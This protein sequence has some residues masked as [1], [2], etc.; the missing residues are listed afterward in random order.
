[1]KKIGRGKIFLGIIVSFIILTLGSILY[2]ENILQHGSEVFLETRP[3]DP[4]D[5]LRG[6]YITLA[7][8]IEN[9]QKVIN[10]ISNNKL[11][12]DDTI[13]I[14]LDNSDKYAKVKKVSLEKPNDKIY[15][16]GVVD[17]RGV[18][19]PQINKF[20]VPED[21]GL[22]LERNSGKM[23]VQVSILNDNA[24]IKK[25]FIDDVEIDFKKK[26]KE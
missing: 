1:M 9:D 18:T 11:K 7:Y 24:M 12:K 15:I 26:K 5:V 10:F 8:K 21:K 17:W 19:L 4:R 23:V 25:I 2:F 16:K 13:F 3:I 22:E 6:D 14:I 20:Y